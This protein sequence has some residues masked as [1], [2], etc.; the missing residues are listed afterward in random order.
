MFRIEDEL[1]SE[2]QGDFP[3]LRAAADELDRRAAVDWNMEPNLA[4]CQNWNNC[5]RRYEIIE[6]D[7]SVRP[8]KQLS[9]IPV[10]EIDARGPR[11]LVPL[12]TRQ[13]WS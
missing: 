12:V 1:H 2:P 5:G 9:R 6:Y 10:L 3:T 11:W 7:T 4:P 13:S 8:W